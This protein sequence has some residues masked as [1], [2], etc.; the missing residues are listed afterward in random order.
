MQQGEA[1]ITTRNEEE[2]SHIGAVLGRWIKEPQV[3]TLQGDLGTG[4][5][6]F[7]RGAA[8]GLGV[9]GRLRAPPLFF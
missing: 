8:G 9:A 7:V 6:V 2:T 5:T 1:Y 4:K 3:I